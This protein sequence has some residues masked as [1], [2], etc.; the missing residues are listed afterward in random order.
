MSAAD[1]GVD[2]QIPRDRA[3]RVGQGWK[4]GGDPLPGAVALPPAEPVQADV[5]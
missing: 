4:P 2:T 3:F 1:G 5:R